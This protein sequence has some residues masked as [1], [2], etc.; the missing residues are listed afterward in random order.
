MAYD[1]WNKYSAQSSRPQAQSFKQ[2]DEIREQEK[3]N[4]INRLLD[5]GFNPFSQED[6]DKLSEYETRLMQEHQGVIDVQPA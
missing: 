5:A 3:S 1:K 4:A 6:W 2:Q